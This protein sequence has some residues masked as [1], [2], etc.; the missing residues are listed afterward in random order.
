MFS[1]I[2]FV[3]PSISLLSILSYPFESLFIIL[4]L[5]VC[6]VHIGF[7][8]LNFYTYIKVYLGYLG[9]L[10]FVGILCD[11]FDFPIVYIYFILYTESC[12][13]VG[14]IPIHFVSLIL[15]YTSYLEFYSHSSWSCSSLLVYRVSTHPHCLLYLWPLFFSF[16]SLD[17]IL[18][19][20]PRPLYFFH[21]ST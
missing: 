2:F 20:H 11:S 15:S 1:L 6:F 4:S 7:F 13:V 9:I 18:E 8:Y 17:P 16:D 19:S 10:V 21:S 3:F 5:W 14:F 12:W